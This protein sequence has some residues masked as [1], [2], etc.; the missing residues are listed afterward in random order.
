VIWQR[1]R[2]KKAGGGE[3]GRESVAAGGNKRTDKEKKYR[4]CPAILSIGC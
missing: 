4:L 2:W 1:K 3:K